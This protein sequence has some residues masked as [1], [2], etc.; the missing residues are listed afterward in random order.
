MV[1]IEKNLSVPP[2]LL[3]YRHFVSSLI[4]DHIKY[5]PFLIKRRPW[6]TIQSSAFRFL[7]SHYYHIS[8]TLYSAPYRSIYSYQS[9][10]YRYNS[11]TSYHYLMTFVTLLSILLQMRLQSRSINEIRHLSCYYLII[12]YNSV[13][14]I[15]AS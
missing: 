15:S 14:I 11:R 13:L 1:L 10:L 3:Q 8:Y 9:P 12:S 4:L 5:G 6:S 2:L 7:S